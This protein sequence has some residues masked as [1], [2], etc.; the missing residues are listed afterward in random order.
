VSCWKLNR[1]VGNCQIHCN[2]EE[3]HLLLIMFEPE[4][5]RYQTFERKPASEHICGLQWGKKKNGEKK[6]LGHHTSHRQIEN[7]LR[8]TTTKPLVYQYVLLSVRTIICRS[9]ESNR[10]INY[11]CI[12]CNTSQQLASISEPVQDDEKLVFYIEPE[13]W[14]SRRSR[15]RSQ[16]CK[17]VKYQK[18]E[19]VD[20]K[21]GGGGRTRERNEKKRRELGT[22]NND[23][24]RP[25]DKLDANLSLWHLQQ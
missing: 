7:P 3:S 16:R 12:Y 23:A 2:H 5:G 24:S 22:Q 4:L 25:R 17:G 13:V 11:K 21:R 19:K 20:I 14:A 6:D 8:Y 18:G 1:W 9:K 15:R 10:T